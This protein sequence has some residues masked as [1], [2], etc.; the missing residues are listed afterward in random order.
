VAEKWEVVLIGPFGAGKSTIGDLIAGRLG[1]HSVSLD[2]HGYY[3]RELGF[4][5]EE[6]M[7]HSGSDLYNGDLYFQT[8]FP[9]A[10]ERLLTEHHNCVFDLGA[11]HTVYEDEAL[12]ARV[13]RAL[14]PFPNVVLVLP[15]PDPE[16]SIRVLR[17]REQQRQANPR[18]LSG[19]F[20]YFGHWIRS[21]CNYDLA[22]IT[23]YTEG[24]T[25]EGTA[26]EVLQ[27][28]SLPESP[29]GGE[30]LSG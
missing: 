15:S 26:E 21:H 7:R 14:A 30:R 10:V 8:F 16:V 18:F 13:Q 1:L 24:M 5:K 25:P 11:G 3:Y 6:F 4:D 19:D 12:F 22:K 17:E 27:A 2:L 20:D 9:A 28:V 29:D 23:V